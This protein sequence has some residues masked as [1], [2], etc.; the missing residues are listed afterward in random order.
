MHFSTDL[1]VIRSLVAVGGKGLSEAAFTIMFLYTVEL[2]P[3]VVR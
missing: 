2:Y 1:W 3:T